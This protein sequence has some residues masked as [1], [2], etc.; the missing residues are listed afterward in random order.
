MSYQSFRPL[1]HHVLR[2][3]YGGALPGV[4]AA[5]SPEIYKRWYMGGLEFDNHIREEFGMDLKFAM[6]NIDGWP[7]KF[8]DFD[9]E[10]P[11]EA[12]ASV[13]VLD[14]FT[15]H[16]FRDSAVSFSADKHAQELADR[17]VETGVDVRAAQEIHPSA[18]C[19]V[20]H[21]YMHS[22]SLKL[23]N[24]G[25]ELLKQLIE[26]TPANHPHQDL[27]QTSLENFVKHKEVI[28]L[29]G[30]FPHRNDMLGRQSTPEEIQ[31]VAKGMRFVV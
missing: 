29:F 3:W 20:Y 18:A 4:N 5:I 19:L 10:N 11:H 22:E 8:Y 14:Q 30:R 15:R 27:L 13:I 24:K 17:F 1:A 7:D 26:R 6:E 12:T 23:Q 25:I 21:P 28:E 2:F 9:A 16:L 31:A